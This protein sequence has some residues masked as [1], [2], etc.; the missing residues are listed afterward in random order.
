MAHEPLIH[1]GYYRTGSTWLQRRVFPRADLGFA[2]LEPRVLLDE[3]FVARNPFWF[4]P[5]DARRAVGPFI[6]GA[7]A[8][9]QV[10]V[11]TEE[12]LAGHPLLGG[13]DAPLIADRLHAALP[14]ARVLVVIREQRAMMLSLYKHHVL[15]RL[16]TETPEGLWRERTITERRT[17]GPTLDVLEYHHLIR[18]YRA[19]FGAG[20]V[21]VLPF[22]LL[23]QDPRAFAGRIASFAGVDPPAAVDARPVNAALPAG[24][25]EA[26]RWLN[27][28]TRAVGLER[29]FRGPV[30]DR[31]IREIRFR[32]LRRL[33]RRL[34]GALSRRPEASWRA[35]VDRLAAGRFGESNRI[36]S[37]LIGV[38][39][40]RFGWDVGA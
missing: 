39:L 23:R 28:L 1:I 35:V 13:T 18:H 29:T 8:R 5:E 38:D 6:A 15:A 7:R 22:D 9:G 17:P 33:G 20:R 2:Q 21:L 24:A 37:E 4:D 30:P 40:D 26:V 3:V 19:R 10:P 36:T 34:P 14:G 12:R 25:V 11:L 31:R 27:V 16:G 32:A